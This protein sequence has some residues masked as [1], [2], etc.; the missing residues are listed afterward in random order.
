MANNNKRAI[1]ERREKIL[2]LLSRGYGQSD[3]ANELGTTRQTISSDMKF[4]NESTKRGLFG[5][6]KET[7][8]TMYQN[9]IESINEIQRECWKRYNTKPEDN[10][11]LSRLLRHQ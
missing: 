4:I 7:L 11:N 3:I 10:P 8:A 1:R 9:C 6:A 2:L 5:L